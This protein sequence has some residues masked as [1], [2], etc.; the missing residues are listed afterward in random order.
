MTKWHRATAAIIATFIVSY[1]CLAF[2]RVEMN[3]F[4]WSEGDRMV[5]CYLFIAGSW[6]SA[7]LPIVLFKDKNST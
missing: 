3:P 7:G 6:F 4:L 5:F 1:V 2:V